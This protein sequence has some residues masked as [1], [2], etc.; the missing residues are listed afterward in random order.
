MQKGLAPIVIILLITA[1]VGG[2][3]LY[4]QQPGSTSTT[5]PTPPPV[6]ETDE[7]TNWKIYT[8]TKY[9]YSFENPGEFV[10][11]VAVAGRSGDEANLETTSSLKL[12]SKKLPEQ[13]LTIWI[14]AAATKYKTID[15][16]LNNLEKGKPN[17]EV[18]TIYSR[19]KTTLGGMEATKYV[20]NTLA[21]N[22]STSVATIRGGNFYNFTLENSDTRPQNISI[23][24]KILSTFKFTN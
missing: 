7:I 12:N 4:Q 23:F 19:E 14:D 13:D 21:G 9:K 2:Y 11:K 20:T 5:Q 1:V 6:T 10:I 24:N 8:N 17:A 22:K 15:E 18:P 16:Y 3:L